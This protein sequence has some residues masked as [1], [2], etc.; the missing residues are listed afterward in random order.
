MVLSQ[1]GTVETKP[2]AN[3]LSIPGMGESKPS[4]T[5]TARSACPHAACVCILKVVFFVTGEV[6]VGKEASG[7]RL[8]RL[9]EN[10][11]TH[12]WYTYAEL[13]SVERL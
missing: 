8:V 11:L 7:L 13:Q 12:E 3:P 9:G 1:G 10:E 4:C 2:G 5:S 6:A